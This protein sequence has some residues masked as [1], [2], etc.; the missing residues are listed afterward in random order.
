MIKHIVIWKL[1]E[2]AHGKS[3]Q[4]NALII[5]DKLETLN[6]K[7]PGMLKI[8]VG[9]D[10]SKTESSADIVLYSEFETKIDFDNYQIHPLHKVLKP[11]IKEARLDR[12]V[13][14][15]EI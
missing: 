11:Y 14:D 3:K 10:F 15:Y 9:I 5:K 7:I 2:T 8:E 4:E 1:K 6:G 13:V 12:I